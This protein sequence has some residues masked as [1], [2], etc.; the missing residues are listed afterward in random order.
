MMK[1]YYSRSKSLI[2]L[3]FFLF[4]T[5][6]SLVCVFSYNV[7]IVLIGVVGIVF[8]GRGVVHFFPA[9]FRR[10]AQV[11]IDEQGIEDRRSGIGPIPWTDI[12]RIQ[13]FRQG[14]TAPPSL[15]MRVRDR[16]RYYPKVRGYS[17]WIKGMEKRLAL[18]DTL[19]INFI[20]LKP[21]FPQAWQYL[22]KHHGDLLDLKARP[23]A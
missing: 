4:L 2:W 5:L 7:F 12:Q 13:Y 9:L 18:E 11:V 19:T 10:S 15:I 6:I 1:F 3:L 20:A 8:F 21:G 23:G 22:Q 16:S 14:R 17:S